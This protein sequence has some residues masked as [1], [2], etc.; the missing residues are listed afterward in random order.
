L[1]CCAQVS[2]R[3]WRAVDALDVDSRDDVR[4]DKRPIDMRA[5]CGAI[6]DDLT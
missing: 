1:T 2:E 3:K 6:N 4:S 5:L